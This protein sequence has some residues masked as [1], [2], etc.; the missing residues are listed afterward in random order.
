VTR[1]GLAGACIDG[2]LFSAAPY[3]AVM[4]GDLQHDETLLPRMLKTLQM[5]HADLVVGSRYS[6]GS[7]ARGFSKPRAAISRTA[8]LL[9]QRVSRV[10]LA[11][12]MSGIFM[13]RREC[14]DAIAGKLATHGF[15]ILLD[16][17][18]TAHGR[19]RIAEIPYVFASRGYGESK[20][21]A[22][23][24][25]DFFGLLLAKATGGALTPR[26]LSFAL[27]GGVGLGVHLLALGAAMTMLGMPFTVAQ[28]AATGIAMTG[29]FL[30]NNELTYRDCRLRG[31]A[32]LRGLFGFYAVSAV[33]AVANVGMA[34]WLYANQPVWWLAGAAGALMSA[35]W[36]YSISTLLV[37]RVR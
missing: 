15:K 28:T 2:M 36:N 12:P 9:V 30:L 7:S 11:D 35:V 37:W 34:S 26:F 1:R 17:I 29:N 31:L 3:V 16:I 19:L 21:D 32:M 6:A 27:V 23:A 18:I 14:F 20:L 25:L 22:Q 8:T 5:G 10:S 13:M 4:D 33:G 24:A